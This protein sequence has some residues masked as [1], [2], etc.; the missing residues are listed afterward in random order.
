MAKEEVTTGAA[1]N[2]NSV[3]TIARTT[4]RELRAIRPAL[5]DADVP[6]DEWDD[7]SFRIVRWVLEKHSCESALVK[8][9]EY[10]NLTVGV[11][12]GQ[13]QIEG[14]ERIVDAVHEKI[15]E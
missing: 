9:V 2:R 6:E 8:A 4:S 7:L 3:K 5:I 14:L 10:L 13:M 1:L 15:G 11:S 12:L